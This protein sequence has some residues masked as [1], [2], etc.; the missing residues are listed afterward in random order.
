MVGLASGCHLLKGLRLRNMDGE[1][2]HYENEIMVMIM[3]E[4]EEKQEKKL[5]EVTDV[6]DMFDQH[7][8]HDLL[9]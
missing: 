2:I 8:Q 4:M 5:F 1:E 6:F 9:E 7:E 3:N